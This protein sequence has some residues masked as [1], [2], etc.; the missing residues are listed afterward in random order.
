MQESEFP[1]L[2]KR[3]DSVAFQWNKKGEKKNR[4]RFRDARNKNKYKWEF[5]RGIINLKGNRQN[6]IIQNKF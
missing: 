1:F 2:S 3:R 4:F 5:N 6:Y